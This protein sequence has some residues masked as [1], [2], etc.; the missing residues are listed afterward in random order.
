M[1]PKLQG[2]AREKALKALPDWC[3]DK[4]RDAIVRHFQFSDLRR[5]CLYDTCG[6]SG[7]SAGPSP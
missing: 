3:Y 5:L 6:G 1:I 4:D 7:R 2:E